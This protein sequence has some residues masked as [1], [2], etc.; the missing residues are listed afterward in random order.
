MDL[1][2]EIEA[3]R[4]IGETI[5]YN[6]LMGLASALWRKSLKEKD[7][8]KNQGIDALIPTMLLFLKKEY[9]EIAKKETDIYDFIIE[10]FFNFG[11]GNDWDG[12]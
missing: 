6:R 7:N 10:T 3:V 4:I 8:P 11:S 12:V 5:G 9:Q 1:K 2:Q